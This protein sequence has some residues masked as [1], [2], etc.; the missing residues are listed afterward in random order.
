M[1]FALLDEMNFAE[2]SSIRHF[3]GFQIIWRKEKLLTVHQ[4][5]AVAFATAIISSPS[6]TVIASGFF[7][8]NVFTGCG[9]VFGHLRVQTVGHGD[10]NHSMSRSFNISR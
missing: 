5:N 9:D 4:E 10:G 8:N 1:F 7:A 2:R 6:A 3:L